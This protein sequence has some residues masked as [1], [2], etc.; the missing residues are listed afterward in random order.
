MSRR[1]PNPDSDVG[2]SRTSQVVALIRASLDRPC[3]AE[4][5]KD[6]QR[7]LCSGMRPTRIVQSVVERTRFFDKQVLSA[8][9]AGVRQVVICGAGY[10]DR[11]LRFRSK[12][13]QFF[14]VDHPATQ[15]DKA[16]RLKDMHAD[17]RWLKLVPAD[18]RFDD[19]AARL[20][21]A[22][23][24]A[25]CPTLFLCEGLL[26]YLSQKVGC[27]L[28]AGLCSRAA[29][30][31]ILACSLAVHNESM[32]DNEAAETVN[33]RRRD[34]QTEPWLTILSSEKYLAVLKETGWKVDVSDKSLYGRMLLVTA[35]PT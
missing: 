31:S 14:E 21:A 26:V 25:T 30:G 3:T 23:H 20:D 24:D 33:A 4:G 5:D 19:T 7:K 15:A 32:G 11:A 17:T 16:R 27:R 12:G 8:I 13:V 1:K 34:G 2:I 22:G 29:E 28:L 6:A 10:D 18:F 9:R 35:K